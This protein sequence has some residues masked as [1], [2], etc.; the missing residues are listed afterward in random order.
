MELLTPF[1][2]NEGTEAH[3]SFLNKY[4]AKAPA[5]EWIPE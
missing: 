4:L 3:R 1:L 5:A 2:L